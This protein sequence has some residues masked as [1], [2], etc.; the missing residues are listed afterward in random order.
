M[1]SSSKP[2]N[3]NVQ[4]LHRFLINLLPL[5]NVSWQ[6]HRLSVSFL[7]SRYLRYIFSKANCLI[8]QNLNQFIGTSHTFQVYRYTEKCS[9]LL[10]LDVFEDTWRNHESRTI[11]AHGQQQRQ[12]VTAFLSPIN[13]T[14]SIQRIIQ[15]LFRLVK[16][17]CS[18]L[19]I[20]VNI[21]IC[22]Y[23]S[24]SCFNTK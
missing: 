16:A 2:T 22:F 19:L 4:N 17:L 18:P 5:K 20:L 10:Y 9:L 15:F 13:S 12:D 11:A 23:T 6:V 21:P 24:R 1:I 14:D 3:G 8:A 7:L